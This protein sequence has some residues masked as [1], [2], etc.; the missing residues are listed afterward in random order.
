MISELRGRAAIWEKLPSC[1]NRTVGV[2]YPIHD[3]SIAAK[4]ARFTEKYTFLAIST[5]C[6]KN[7]EV[8]HVK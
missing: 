3:V 4:T 8:Y 5:T 2:V 7:T 1:G 6:K